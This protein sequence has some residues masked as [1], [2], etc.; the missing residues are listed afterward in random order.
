MTAA[1]IPHNEQ[2]RLDALYALLCMNTPPEARFD[3]IVQF[4]SEEF[5][6][7]IVLLSLVDRDRQW[8]KAKVG[9][10][11]CESARDLSFCAH[12]IRTSDNFVIGDAA[13][14]PRF[15]DNPMVTGAPHVRFYAGAPLEVSPGCRVGTL[16]IIDTKPRA[17]DAIDNRI[18]ATLRDLIV[19][20][21]RGE[22]SA[23]GTTG[24]AHGRE[25]AA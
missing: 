21:L 18:L 4:A 9:M 1:A 7:P 6:A 19:R 17:F 12:A 5:D 10:E 20:E 25:G 2:D 16:C 22:S 8:F 14:D 15:F 23:D 3:R 24:G 13:R 11:V